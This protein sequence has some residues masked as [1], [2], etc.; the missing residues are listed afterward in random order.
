MADKTT[1][2]EP[3]LEGLRYLKEGF[4][5]TPEQDR[6]FALGWPHVRRLDP[7]H[8]DDNDPQASAMRY[9]DQ[10]DFTSRMVWGYRTAMGLA[11]AWGQ[12]AIFDLAPAVRGLRIEAEEAIWNARP[13][14]AE[15]ARALL[16]TRMTAPVGG[17]GERTP[18]TFVLLL[19]ALV[20]SEPI[21]DAMTSILE[22]M[23]IT[24][25]RQHWALPPRVTYQLGHLMLRV[26][27]QT[28]A[29]LRRRLQDVLR[30]GTAFHNG[31]LEELR[32]PRSEITHLRSIHLILHGA[33]AAES[34]SDHSPEWY[35]HI[36]DDYSIVQMRAALGR[37]PYEL[38][39]RL[40]FLGGPDVL[41]FYGKR[42][43]WLKSQPQQLL[44]LEQVA[45]IKHPKVVHLLLRM[46]RTSQVRRQ[47]MWWFKKHAAY[48]SP[49]L[50][51][52][53][54]EQ[55]ASAAQAQDMLD[56]LGT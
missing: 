46:A 9:L 20:G 7:D 49:V 13:L 37:T 14:Q 22:E 23:T 18:R 55:R 43:D 35:T 16:R 42:L 48:V 33:E 34:S 54:E 12:P 3:E 36:H 41:R 6:Q 1:S 50:E 11:R 24:E 56:T 27:P 19:E 4:C 52:L 10:L 53:V 30:R 44:F 31:P 29:T 8:P 28:A 21:A 5:F 17:I 39:A 15:E 26:S 25:L 32:L 2:A 45:P 38:D 47:V 51:K 40:V